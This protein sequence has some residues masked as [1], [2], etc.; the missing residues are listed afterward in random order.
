VAWQIQYLAFVQ[1]T[2][3]RQNKQTLGSLAAAL[4]GIELVAL[5]RVFPD[6]IAL[7]ERWSHPVARD[8]HAQIR[9][10]VRPEESRHVLIWRYV[11]HQLIVPKGTQVIDYYLQNTNLGRRQLGAPALDRAGFTR[12]VGPAAPSLRQLLGKERVVM[13]EATAP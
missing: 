7:C 6:L 5:Q 12:L 2:R 1:L 4:G 10:V 11:F 13:E 8:L 9:D 3:S